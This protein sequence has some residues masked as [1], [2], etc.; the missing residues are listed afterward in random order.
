MKLM[1]VAVVALVAA[2]GC[3]KSVKGEESRWSSVNKQ[4]DEMAALYPGFKAAIEERRTAAKKAYDAAQSIDDEKQKISKLSEANRLL[5][6]GFVEQLSRVDDSIKALRASLVDAAGAKLEP[7]EKARAEAA[8]AET[9]KSLQAIE[10]RL[11][12]G[13]PT[14]TAADAVMKQIDKDLG[15]ATAM[16]AKATPAA[17]APPPAEPA[18]AEPTTWTCEYCDNQ[19]EPEATACHN[20]GAARPSAEPAK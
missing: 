11:R 9:K 18:A 1:L 19:N 2:A 6:G 5:G 7:E 13:A 3:K 17:A 8:V 20:C 16:L 12:R 15:A 4:A 14:A 10:E